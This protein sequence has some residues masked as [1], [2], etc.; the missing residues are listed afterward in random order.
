MLK[1]RGLRHTPSRF[2]DELGGAIE[3]GATTTDKGVFDRIA[4]SSISLDP[5]QPRELTLSIQQLRQHVTGEVDL[6]NSDDP[7]IRDEFEELVG[8]ANSIQ[9]IGLMNPVEVYEEAPGKHKLIA[10]ERRYLAHVLLNISKIRAIVGPK[11]KALKTR[12]RQLIEN[13]QRKD[14]SL[15]ETINGLQ[16][17]KSELKQENADLTEDYLTTTVGYGARQAR[18]YYN[19][20]HAPQDVHEAIASQK[21]TNLQD[22]E[23]VASIK[24]AAERNKMVEFINTPLSADYVPNFD[25]EVK[26]EAKVVSITKPGKKT[27]KGRP[28]SHVSL[29]KTE[30][31]AALQ[32]L[33]Q[34]FHNKRDYNRL[35]KD[36]DWSDKKSVKKAWQRFWEQLEQMV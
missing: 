33:I 10:G 2:V 15:K 16:L 6:R 11:P 12:E 23:R 27:E 18:R 36:I 5:S 4:V 26:E 14:L 21:L 25:S 7:Q 8:L 3:E 22:A 1:K 32:F 24:D 13:V 9:A 20:L 29:G 31:V 34:K 19:V 30:N 35:Y 28:V 17:I